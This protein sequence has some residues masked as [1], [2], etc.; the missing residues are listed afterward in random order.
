M[1][2]HINAH[3]VNHTDE[4]ES[5]P[6]SARM[7]IVVW[8]LGTVALVLLAVILTIRTL[9]L[10]TVEDRANAAVNQ[11]LQEFDTFLQQGQDPETAEP[12]RS[13]QRVFNVYL[14]RQIPD[15][16]EILVGVLGGQ[17]IQIDRNAHKTDT[18]WH[19]PAIEEIKNSDDASGIFYGTGG[20]RI[21]WGRVEIHSS[22][23]S[24]SDQFIVAVNLTPEIDR[25]KGEIRTI[26]A[27]G[28]GG[29]LLTSIIAWGIAG[30]I[31]NPVRQLRSV[32]T[33]ITETDLTARVPVAGT[34]ENRELA[35]TFNAMLDRIE[36]VTDKQARFVDDAGHELRT[37]ITVIRGQLELLE[38]GDSEQ[39]KRSTALAITELD[40]MARIVNELLTLAVA[41][42]PDFVS[43]R[44]TD[45]ADLT[46]TLEDKAQTLGDRDWRLVELAEIETNLDEQRVSQ[47]MLEIMNNAVRHTCSGDRIDIGT[48]IDYRRV[49]HVNTTVVEQDSSDE[50]TGTGGDTVTANTSSAGDIRPSYVNFWVRDYGPGIPSDRLPQLFE[51]F[52]RFSPKH[53][54]E[55]DSQGAGLGLSIVKAIAEAHG[56]TAWVESAE[57]QYT[58]FGLRLPVTLAQ[59]RTATEPSAH[60]RKEQT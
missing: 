26:A 24:L 35:K 7:R 33:R 36:A 37:P 60:H 49:P 12:F 48:T 6:R 4:P 2:Q 41:D 28:L 32:A 44:R 1:S 23:S 11:E 52:T 47:A 14:S 16:N 51:R 53:D 43:P 25:V 31:L 55:Q 9:L 34:D 3:P 30:Q 38:Q 39:R 40:R 21:H 5:K 18:S 45:V 10:A 46:I 50:G 27:V 56:G 58:T 29:L 8:I 57:G 59:G 13:T 54:S 17:A 19:T 20:D 15:D 22:G 42:R